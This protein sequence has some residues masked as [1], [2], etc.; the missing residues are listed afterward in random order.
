MITTPTKSVLDSF[1]SIKDELTDENMSEEAIDELYS[2]CTKIMNRNKTGVVITKEK[3][4]S[5]FDFEDIIVFIR[6]YSDFISEV[7]NSKN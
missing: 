7:T 1:V 4:H 3:L 2:L 6:A 5:L